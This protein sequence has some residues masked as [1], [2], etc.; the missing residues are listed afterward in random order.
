[1]NEDMLDRLFERVL[2]YERRIA[3]LE[4]AERNETTPAVILRI[5]TTGTV[6][7]DGGVVRIGSKAQT[8]GTDK[9]G[10]QVYKAETAEEL[11]WK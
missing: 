5:A 6:W 9:Y 11:T 4:K 8:Y 7:T 1:M 3:K 2:A 10:S